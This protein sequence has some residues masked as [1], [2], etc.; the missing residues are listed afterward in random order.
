MARDIQASLR[1]I[2]KKEEEDNGISDEQ[3][4]S[5]IANWIIEKK[6]NFDVW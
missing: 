6:L 3:V 5:I 1:A 4:S 2:V